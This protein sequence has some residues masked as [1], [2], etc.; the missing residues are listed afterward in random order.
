MSARIWAIALVVVG[1]AGW[2][3]RG[4]FS[5]DEKPPEGD[6]PAAMEK[7]MEELATPGEMHKWLAKFDGTWDVAAIFSDMDGSK[8]NEKGTATF[9]MM[10]GGRFSEQT[11]SG[12]FKGKTFDG[13]GFT[14]YDNLKKQFTNYWFDSMG[15][16]PS[17]G[18]GDL[19]GDG[20]TLTLTGTW[21]IPNGTVPFQF[22]TTWVDAKTFTFTMQMDMGAGLAPMGEMT[23]T[24]K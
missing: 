10:L 7:M 5:D 8:L 16:A 21:D 17:V 22:V 24:R 2:L 9:K 1:A 11:Y 19:S 12:T 14:G 23:Y 15:T 18:S 3:G 4:A 13:R 20:K 6:D